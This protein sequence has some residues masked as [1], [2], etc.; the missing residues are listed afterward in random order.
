MYYNN[1]KK[2]TRVKE[3]LCVLLALAVLAAALILVTGCGG[4]SPDNYG[5]EMRLHLSTEPLRDESL[6]DYAD[7]G[8]YVNSEVMLTPRLEIEGFD[9]S[10]VAYTVKSGNATI[11]NS[12]LK[13]SAL[14]EVVIYATYEQDGKIYQSDD[15][16][17]YFSERRGIIIDAEGLLQMANS[18]DT[19][20]LAADIDL[21]SYESWIPIENFTGT[22]Y[23]NGF[24]IKGI[25]IVARSMDE[26]KGLFAILGGTVDNLKIEGKISCSGEA[27]GLGLLCGRSKGKITNV[28]ASGTV[29]APYSNYVGGIVGYADGS[30]TSGCTSDVSVT[31]REYVGGQVG[32]MASTRKGDVAFA[33]NINYGR[34]VGESYVGGVYGCFTF[35][36]TSEEN[37]ATIVANKNFGEVFGTKSY[38]GGIVGSL[39]G[40]SYEVRLSSRYQYYYSRVSLI[41]CSNEANVTGD[42]YVGGVIGKIGNYVTEVLISTNS[43]EISGNDNIGGVVG[44]ASVS[45]IKDLTNN[46]KVLGKAYVGGIAGNSG[47]KLDK[48]TNNGEINVIGFKLTE[49]NMK[50]SYAGGIVGYAIEI[51]NCVNNANI[52]AGAAGDFVGGIAGYVMA[53]LSNNASIK[54][55]KNHGAVIGTRYVGGAFGF[56][57]ITSNLDNATVLVV[58]NVNDGEVTGSDNY[59]GGVIGYAKGTDAYDRKA[60]SFTSYL[61]IM[62]CE[63]EAD[64]IGTDYVGG[65]VGYADQYVAEISFCKNSSDVMGNEYVGGYAGYTSNATSIKNLT[66][67]NTVTGKAYVGGIAGRGG[68]AQSCTNN[69]SV[70]LVGYILSADNQLLSYA[71]GIAGYLY[72]AVDCIN[73]SNIDASEAGDFVGGIAGYISISSDVSGNKNHGE[74]KGCSFVGGLFGYCTATGNN[75]VQFSKNINDGAVIGA[76]DYVGGVVGCFGSASSKLGIIRVTECKTEANVTGADFV[77]GI[78]GKCDSIVDETKVVWSTNI[79][80]GTVKATGEH[81]GKLY[82]S[83]N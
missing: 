72:G 54:D 62:E 68:L 80:D 14:G 26:N 61:K 17:L 29:D 76:N 82:G 10:R 43:G 75:T 52:E 78:A 21:S 6:G 65:I 70:N 58:S 44:H 13:A 79:C 22:L 39:S 81:Y 40:G 53:P 18:S 5:G 60:G 30:H 35:A 8:Y 1:Q 74:I 42:G 15:V 27:S 69:G 73:N 24:T 59:V 47:S 66:N 55:N 2:A 45:T 57:D 83:M 19:F 41:E 46:G 63:N 37:N 71:G 49:D 48:C 32:Y 12:K 38:V 64:V 23:G 4:A 31:G 51:E 9:P 34:V 25:N 77:G 11:E 36:Q 16:T 7:V 28:S 3:L 50:V 56:V 20:F 67:S 33:D